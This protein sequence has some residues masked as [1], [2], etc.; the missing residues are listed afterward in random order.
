MLQKNYGLFF[1]NHRFD[2]YSVGYQPPPWYQSDNLPCA[3]PVAPSTFVLSLYATV[4]PKS[5][6]Y[7]IL[8]LV[9][10]PDITFS[11][12]HRLLLYSVEL[13]PLFFRACYSV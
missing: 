5:A 3:H 11:A 12:E 4:T 13:V 6:I 8:S 9:L 10:V 1:R 7:G 2:T